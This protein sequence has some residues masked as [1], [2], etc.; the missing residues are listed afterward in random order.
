MNSS[1]P[2]E[3]E[4]RRRVGCKKELQQAVIENVL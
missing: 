2:L 3:T 1:A 4:T